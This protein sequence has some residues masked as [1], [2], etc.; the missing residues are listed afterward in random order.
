MHPQQG[1]SKPK[2]CSVVYMP[3][4]PLPQYT[5]ARQDA[6]PESHRGGEP[7]PPV[8]ACRVPRAAGMKQHLR[9]I[10]NFT[11]S[12]AVCMPFISSTCL[13]TL[14]G[15][16][17]TL[18]RSGKRRYLTAF[19]ISRGEAL[20]PVSLSRMA[21]LWVFYRHLLFAGGRTCLALKQPDFYRELC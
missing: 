18:L 3:M 1:F 5:H 9:I 21:R 15:T 14:A 12:F 8:G 10:E 6:A 17:S 7:Q 16:S 4:A 19:P 13:I 11:S 20:S 2:P